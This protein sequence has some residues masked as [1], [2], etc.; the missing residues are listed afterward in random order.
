MSWT[1]E[2]SVKN[3][4]PYDQQVRIR[5]GQVFENK[6]IGTG[7]QNVAASKD[8]T[9]VLP[10]NST[11]KLAIE[12]WCINQRLQSPQGALNVTNFQVSSDFQTQQDLWD[13]MNT[14]TI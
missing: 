1:V 3:D 11:Q 13:V 2:I 12:V 6:K 10:H 9:F 4:T 5:K 7:K 8:Y 14:P